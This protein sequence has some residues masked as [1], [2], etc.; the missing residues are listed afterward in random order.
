MARQQAS[1][2]MLMNKRKVLIVDDEE[3]IRNILCD[4]L[5][6]K[7]YRTRSV[8]DGRELIVQLNS[9]LPDIV[10]LDIQL[11]DIN[12]LE[13]L[14]MIKQIDEDII[15]IM[16]SGYATEKKAKQ[17]FQ[18]GAFDYIRKPFDLEQVAAMLSAVE[19]TRF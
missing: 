10:F 9:E 15:V 19:I 13:L 6:K 12:G 7:G 18:F 16:I 11:P 2:R 1:E 3:G 4:F 17:T 5:D 14:K 8:A